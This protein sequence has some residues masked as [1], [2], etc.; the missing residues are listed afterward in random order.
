MKTCYIQNLA[1]ITTNKCNLD[2]AHCLRGIK[3]DNDMSDEI[4]ES[5]L[6]Q[7]YGIGNLSINGGEPTLALAKLEKIISYV[8]EK[9][10]L[11]DEFTITINGTIYSE[12]LLKLLNEIN[13]YIN[14]NEVNTLLAISLDKY[15]LDEIKRLNMLKEFIKNLDM[16]EKSKFFCGVRNTN[17]KLFREGNAVNLD[18]KLTVPL[19]PLKPVITYVN[20]DKKFDIEN[21]LCNIGPVITINTNGII[22]ES[23]ASIK[24]QKDLYNY[25]NILEESI[26]DICLKNGAP[27]LKPKQ[28]ERTAAKLLKKYQTYNK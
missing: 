12:E 6:N 23:D 26:E 11:V 24:H 14:P 16:Y 22:T 10:I 21:G 15:H 1:L 8:I 3:D 28:F 27:I 2:C 4:I 13:N 9:H 25:G 18:S 5:V 19:R 7:V 20:K 17:K